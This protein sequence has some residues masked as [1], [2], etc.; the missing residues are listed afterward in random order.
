MTTEQDLDEMMGPRRDKPSKLRATRNKAPKLD[1]DHFHYTVAKLLNHAIAPA[2]LPSHE[3]VC[4]F[5]LEGRGKRSIY[6][7]MRNKKRGCVAGVPDVLITHAGRAFWI[8]LKTDIGRLSPAQ[9]DMHRTLTACGMPVA[10]ARSLGDVAGVLAA[11]GIPH[12][13]VTV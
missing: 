1:E 4:W 2:G 10:V 6:E 9:V 7:G 13:R 3:G 12:R 8:E 5:A 11:H